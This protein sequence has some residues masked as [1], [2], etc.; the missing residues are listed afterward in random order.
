M[1]YLAVN[2]SSKDGTVF[3]GEEA[4]AVGPHGRLPLESKP[5]FWTSNIQL[6]KSITRQ[7]ATKAVHP[8]SE[9]P[10]EEPSEV[11]NG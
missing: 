7:R 10:L 9:L 2:I 3:F 6:V 8:A 1:S 11:S 4:R 5:T